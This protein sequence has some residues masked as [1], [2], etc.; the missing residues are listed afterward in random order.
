MKH[1]TIQNHRI[2][3][4]TLG[5]AQFG[6]DYGIANKNGQPR[7]ED[8]WSLLSYARE[9]GITA[10]DTAR[11]YGNSEE[12]IGGF[13][14]AGQFTVVTKFK[15]PLEALADKNKAKA[16]ARN[17]LR[18]SCEAL[19]LAQ[20]PVCLLHQEKDHPIGLVAELLPDILQDLKN[21]GLIQAG[22]ISIFYPHELAAIADLEGIEAIQVPMNVL[23]LRLL[24]DD[25]LL[26]MAR[27]GT[28]VFVRSVFLQGLLLM[29]PGLVPDRLDFARPYLRALQEL[30]RQAGMSTAQLAFS[31]IRDLPEVAS[32]VI[33]AE[34]RVQIEENARLLTGPGLPPHTREEVAQLFKEVPERLITPALW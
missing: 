10:L 20:I 14:D 12:V 16:A 25:L 33:G 28:A 18:Q 6:M 13:A 15:L 32:L 11:H 1:F 23:D 24:A 8:S 22:G 31:Y 7:Q 29:D 5:T 19:H 4:I 9:K 2:P 17:S 21:E 34:N 26:R 27:K 3:K 30:A